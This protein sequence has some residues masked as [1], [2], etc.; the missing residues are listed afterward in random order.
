MRHE[1]RADRS[2]MV[3]RGGFLLCHTALD[4]HLEAEHEAEGEAGHR[5]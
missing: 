4:L 3:C 2:S 1:T 5:H